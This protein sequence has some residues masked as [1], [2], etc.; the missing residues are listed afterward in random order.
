MI[1]AYQHESFWLLIRN[2]RLAESS[3]GRLGSV[4]GK[5]AFDSWTGAGWTE[6]PA[7]AKRFSTREEAQQYLDDNR[8]KMGA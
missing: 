7:A 5:P 6:E 3:G 8:T 2:F 4:R 1:R